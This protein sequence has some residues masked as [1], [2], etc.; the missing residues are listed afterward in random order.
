MSKE[1]KKVPL[2]QEHVNLNAKMLDF[3]G[4]EMPIQYSSV[5]QEC[6]A[7]RTNVGVFDVSHMGEFM[8]T[9]DEAELFVNYL[10][11]NDI[12]KLANNKAI[13]SPI[14]NTSGGIIDD[15]IAY[16]F[17]PSEILLC[18]NA[19]NIQ[20]DFD[21][22]TSHIHNFNCKIENQSND[23]SLL[24]VQGP[25]AIEVLDEIFNVD[26]KAVPKFGC[27]KKTI[28]N[29]EYIFA[30][31]GYTGEDGMEVFMKN[32]SSSKVWSMLMDKKVTPCGLA[33]RDVLR[34]EAGYPLYGQEL[35]DESTPFESGISWTVK[36]N[37][38]N[39]LGK[40][41]LEK[42]DQNLKLIKMTLDKGIPRWQYD[43][44]DDSGSK[45][46]Y[47]TSGTMSFAINKPVAMALV[48]VEKFKKTNEIFIEIRN[49]KYIASL[50][51]GSFLN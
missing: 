23:F 34:L 44:L 15:L 30:R 24:A 26:L 10:I 50:V 17:S 28:E 16:K 3:A 39:F 33:S 8:I 6:N 19:S 32:T 1:S 20:K 11:T 9:G 51:N 4:F 21:W 36:M 2:H 5:K 43:V 45:I 46:G 27:I 38:G 29:S 49:K 13:Y 47:V 35:N 12:E 48:E 18:V 41:S 40:E 7:V 14:C 31:T 37:K 25:N 42:R 22:I